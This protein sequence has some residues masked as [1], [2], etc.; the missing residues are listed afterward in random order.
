MLALIAAL[1]VAGTAAALRLT[2][3]AGTDTLVD[4]DNATYRAT[5]RFKEKFGDD[6]VVVLAEGDLR[7]LVLTSNLGRLLGLEG[8]LAGNEPEQALKALPDACR[9]IAELD[10]SQVVFGP[11]TFLNQSVVQI[12][13]VLR[14]QIASAQKLA[15]RQAE[16]ARRT[17]AAQGL[18]STEQDAAARQA[19]QDVLQQFQSDLFRIAAQYDIRSA[20]R[21][22]DPQFVS[23]IVFDETQPGG[24][25]KARFSYLF[26]NSESALISIRMRPGLS[27]SERSRAIGLY[28]EAVSS[29]QFKLDEGRYV[30]SG[31]PAVVEGLADSL[32]SEIFVLLGAAVLI[33]A[34][35]LGLVLAPPLR[36]LP[37]FVAL[38]ASALTFGILSLFGGSLT[39]A[40]IAVLPVLIGLAV[41]Y[42]IQLQARWNEARGEGLPP[43]EAAVAA[44]EVGGR[45]IGTAVLATAAGF[46]CLALSPVPMVRSFGLLLVLGVALGFAV[47][48]SGGLA[49][50]CLAARPRRRGTRAPGALRR[51]GE[52]V[53]LARARTGVRLRE[54]GTR[55]LAVAIASP[56]RVL[57]VAAAL[58]LC[59]WI[60]GSQ[61]RVISDIRELA[62]SGLPALHDVSE[63]QDQTGVSGEINVVVRS[64]DLARP[65]VLNWMRSYQDRVLQRHGFTGARSCQQADLC[66]AVSL[67]DLFGG[68]A[69]SQTA[70]QARSL[71][72]AIPPYFSQAVISRDATGRE[73]G[74][75]ANIAFGIPV[76]P[77]DRQQALI[78]DIRG[79][80]D[81]PGVPGPPSGTD[82]EVAGLPALA[83]QANEDLSLSRYWL[84][85]VALL[86]VALVL[87]AVYRSVWRAAVPLVP[88][89][90]ATGWSALVVAA[91]DIPLNPM[92]AT[93][94]AL[95]IAIATEFSVI[96]SARYE[97]ERRGGLSVGEALRHTYERTGTA[98][99]ASGVTAIAGFAALAAS[100]IR[101]LRDF[102]LVTIADLGVA[103]AGVMLVLPAALVWAESARQAPAGTGL[104]E[105]LAGPGRRAPKAQATHGG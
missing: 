22:D 20:P 93:L 68:A 18:S 43:V 85:P 12:D 88:I 86:A 36:L 71:L 51:L 52:R 75:T 9:K 64:D 32:R 35:V 102:G 91:M 76:M 96:L 69:G 87:T 80:I 7:N 57:T 66:P 41:D 15:A 55:A 78:E 23:K 3:N 34:I 40:S 89:V 62:P 99:L 67:P 14:G 97:A 25:P 42:A 94:G 10:S 19:Q 54:Q 70:E 104:W 37:L 84:P 16:Q 30:V 39:M 81:P 79:Q 4:K 100:D 92:S 44:S 1:A 24:V 63:L 101:M 61:S 90:F 48:L 98:V 60:A 72:K 47:A 6:A 21:L 2:A 49:A 46:A 105:R 82:V 29:D 83:A 53:E 73:I 26:P 59:G 38:A 103:L 58:A 45:V 31:V 17:A 13:A 27:E 95:V 56:G 74:D 5:Q 11:A 33:M 77:L 65:A 50:L 8:C 28:R